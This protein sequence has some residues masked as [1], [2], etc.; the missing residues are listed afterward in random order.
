VTVTDTFLTDDD[1]HIGAESGNVTPGGTFASQCM[2]VVRVTRTGSTDT[3]TQDAV[4]E[5]IAMT[6]SYNKWRDN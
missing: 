5:S 4:L 2:L 3:Y 6:L 1:L